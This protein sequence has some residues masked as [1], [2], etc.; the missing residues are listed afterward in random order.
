GQD[1]WETGSKAYPEFMLGEGED[2]K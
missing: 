2:Q 1:M